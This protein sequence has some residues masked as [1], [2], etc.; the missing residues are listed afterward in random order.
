[1][2]DADINTQRRVL[3]SADEFALLTELDGKVGTMLG[4]H[5]A[6]LAIMDAG[7]RTDWRQQ[8]DALQAVMTASKNMLKNIDEAMPQLLDIYQARLKAASMQVGIHL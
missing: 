7:S 5:N 3:Q 6:C 8:L 4:F 2:A 1:M